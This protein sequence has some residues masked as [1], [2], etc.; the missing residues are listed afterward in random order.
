M[1][2]SQNW[3]FIHLSSPLLSWLSITQ[4]LSSIWQRLRLSLPSDSDSNSLFW[5]SET[6]RQ[7]LRLSFTQTPSSSTQNRNCLLVVALFRSS[8]I[9]DCC[10]E[11]RQQSRHPSRRTTNQRNKCTGALKFWF[12][13]LWIFFPS[14]FNFILWLCPRP[15]P[16]SH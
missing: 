11:Q 10:R 6:V 8:P 9:V 3:Y 7:R 1:N 15:K 5:P 16:E 4:T 13:Q 2:E 12:P 14:L